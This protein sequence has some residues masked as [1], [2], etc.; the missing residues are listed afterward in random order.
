MT[1][2]LKIYLNDLPF[3]DETVRK[4][5][6]N[7]LTQITVESKGYMKAWKS[8]FEKQEYHFLS[9]FKDKNTAVSYMEKIL[10][11][12]YIGRVSIE[13][14]DMESRVMTIPLSKN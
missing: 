14:A 13:N 9:E 5:C 11:L 7:N 6:M 10:E 3:N 8:F 4:T 12:E 1:Y 2:T